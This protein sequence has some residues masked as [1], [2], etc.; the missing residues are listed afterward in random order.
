MLEKLTPGRIVLLI[1][2]EIVCSDSLT[3]LSYVLYL[4]PIIITIRH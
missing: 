3:H 1:R 2:M 4:Y